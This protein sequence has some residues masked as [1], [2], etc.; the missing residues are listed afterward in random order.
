ML[1]MSKKMFFAKTVDLCVILMY[2]KA[3]FKGVSKKMTIENG[4]LNDVAD[5]EINNGT[6]DIPKSV[7]ILGDWAF[8]QCPSLVEIKIP[9]GIRSIGRRAFRFCSSLKKVTI[10]DSLNPKCIADGAFSFC[11]ALKTVEVTESRE[12]SPVFKSKFPHDVKFVRI[13]HEK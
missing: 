7:Q 9:D 3:L 12:L 6:F 8:Y 11:P 10:P 5:R 1:V 2:N 4:I 13:K